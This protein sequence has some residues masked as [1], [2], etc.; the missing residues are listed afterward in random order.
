MR[1]ISRRD[2]KRLMNLLS[3]QAEA[4]RGFC[5]FFE[6]F[7]VFRNLF[8]DLLHAF[9]TNFWVKKVEQKNVIL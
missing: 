7:V 2:R 3:E 5:N 9:Q 4:S 6:V 8:R 1:T